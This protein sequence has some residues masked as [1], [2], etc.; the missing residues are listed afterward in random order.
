MRRPDGV[1]LAH[2]GAACLGVIYYGLLASGALWGP[3]GTYFGTGLYDAYWSSVTQGRLDVPA[4][5]AYFE[6]HYTTDGRAYLYHGAGPLALRS[7]FGWADDL[8]PMSVLSVFLTAT[9]GTAC[10]H[11]ALKTAAKRAA[12]RGPAAV[13]LAAL[14]GMAVWFG[15]PGALLA[16]N[17][18][19]YHEPT[20][21]AFALGGGFVLVLTRVA[22]G[23]MTIRGALLPLALLAAGTVHARPNLALGLIVGVCLLAAWTLLRDR[24]RVLP[25]TAAAVGIM[26]AS[27]VGYA[28]LNAAKFGEATRA[29]GAFAADAPVL[30]GEVF[31]HLEHPES[32]RA[33][34]FE[35]HGRFNARRILPNAALYVAALPRE[36]A[37]GA[38]GRSM[39]ETYRRAT[40]PRLGWIRVEAPWIGMAFLWPVFFVLAGFALAGDRRTLAR[41]GLLASGLAVAALLMLSYGTVTLR[42]RIDVWPLL[43]FAAALGLPGLVGTMSRAGAGGPSVI[44]LAALGGLALQGV[45]T[46]TE[47]VRVYSATFGVWEEPTRERCEATYAARR[48]DADLAERRCALGPKETSGQDGR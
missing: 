37:G 38:A 18:S 27:C 11:L 42:Y 45:V 31:W 8:V 7:L 47:T 30:Y 23:A 22:F 12:L 39:M 28:G 10:Y 19:F 1:G 3:D 9:V 46:T 35:A 25:L 6:G 16:A 13:A 32:P 2:A 21:L 44:G 14:L 43:A 40:E 48:F 33:A 36:G 17:T 15:G 4:R 34:T 20:A 29:H 5:T 24:W 41:R 26:A